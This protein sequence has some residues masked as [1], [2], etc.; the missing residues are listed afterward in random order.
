MERFGPSTYGDHVASVYD[1]WESEFVVGEHQLRFLRNL[2]GKGPA[3]ELGIGTG[4]VALA[5]LEKGV[6]VEGIEASRAMLA[7]LRE[8]PHGRDL[9]VKVGNMAR[10]DMGTRYPL[11]Y[12]VFN[13][14]FHLT[15]QDDQVRCFE[16][17]A[18]HLRRDG[19]FVLETFYP[20][21]AK[22]PRDQ[23]VRV[24]KVEVDR[25][26]V[27]F[28]TLDRLNQRVTSQS[29][30]F[31]GKGVTLYP[32]QIRFAWPSEMDLMARLAGLRLA[33]RYGGWDRRPFQADAS[34]LYVSVYRRAAARDRRS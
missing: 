12:V 11:V 17:A 32:N 24:K 3:H 19:C 5:L 29:V 18:R 9:R 26:R 7:R 8:K 25:V 28:A 2:A 1:D 20:D 16:N 6:R 13:T 23:M 14:L 21:P 4:R 31:Q 15:R 27:E 10:V 34:S 33:G 22:F 30:V